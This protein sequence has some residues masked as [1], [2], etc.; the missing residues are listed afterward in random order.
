MNVATNVSSVDVS[1]T[2][3]VLNAVMTGDVTAGAGNPT[4]NAPI[5]L[6]GPGTPT[7]ITISVTA[8]N[9]GTPKTYTITVNRAASSDDTLSEL[10]VTANAVVQPLVPDFNANILTYTVNVATTVDQVTV[11]ATKSDLNAVMLIGSVTVPAGTPSE[12]ETFPLNGPGTQTVLSIAVTA[13]SGGAPKTY[14]ITVNRAAS[15]DDTLSELTVTAN[16]VVQPLVP[17]FNANILTYTVNVA[18]TVDQVT[19][20]ATKSDLNAVMLIGSVTVPAGT[21]SEQETFPL[22]GPGT[23]TVLSIAVTAQSGGAPK[24]YTI[25]IDRD[26]GP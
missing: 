16:A 13:Q 12:Q 26:L 21:P 10:T 18:T 3:A 15:S 20:A 5:S 2:K 25:A 9:G 6:N 4:G 19:V 7:N 24:T 17:D 23:Q 14:T 11:A 22:N 8:P 1:A